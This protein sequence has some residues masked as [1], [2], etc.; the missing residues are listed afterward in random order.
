MK[1]A[2]LAANRTVAFRRVDLGGRFDREFHTAAMT[3]TDMSNQLQL[4]K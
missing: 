3:P 1:I 4:P 2:A